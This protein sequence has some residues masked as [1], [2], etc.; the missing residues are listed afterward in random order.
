[1]LFLFQQLSNNKILH[2]RKQGDALYPQPIFLYV[3]DFHNHRI[4][5]FDV[6]TSTDLNFIRKWGSYCNMSTGQGCIDPDGAAG[7]LELGDEQFNYPSGI[8]INSTG[9]V[10]VTENNNERIQV[11]RRS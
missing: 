9:Y 4:Q 6:N 1:M 7:P 3:L 2:R 5:I 10:Y 11:F 8:A